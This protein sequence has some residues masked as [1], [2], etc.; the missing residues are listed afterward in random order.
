MSQIVRALEGDASLDD[1][2]EGMK[3]SSSTDAV[4]SS[5]SSEYDGT[6]N[7]EMK[8]FRKTPNNVTSGE[9]TSSEHGNTSEFTKPSP[10][11]SAGDS[12]EFIRKLNL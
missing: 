4:Y 12:K 11:R 3:Y 8:R 1:L 10:A 5:G 9:F 7:S 2:N 6:Y